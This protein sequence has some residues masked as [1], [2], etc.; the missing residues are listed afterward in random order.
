MLPVLLLKQTLDA[1]FDPGPLL[2]TGGHVALA[3]FDHLRTHGAVGHVVLGI[4][5]V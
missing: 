5:M 1:P 2:L 4:E 3:S